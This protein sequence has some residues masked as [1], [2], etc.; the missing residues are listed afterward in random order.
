MKKDSPLTPAVPQLSERHV[1]RARLLKALAHPVRLYFVEV[2]SVR[3]HCVCELQS[4]V[5]LD[6]STVSKHLSILRSAGIVRDE[7]RGTQ[8]FYK[9]ATPCLLNIFPC[10]EGAIEADLKQRLGALKK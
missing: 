8:V 7:R 3:E 10:V 4:L 9:L 1:T 5:G 2:L 6:L